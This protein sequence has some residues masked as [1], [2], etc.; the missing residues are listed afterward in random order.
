MESCSFQSQ[1]VSVMEI[2]AK[3]ALAEINRRVDASC[4]VLRLEISQSRRD[5]DSLRRKSELLEAELRRTRLRAR[6]RGFYPPAADRC[7]PLVRIVLNKERE[8]AAW[9]RQVDQPGQCEDVRPA[10]ES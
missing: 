10:A 7:S 3:A 8:A 1:L 6:R 2:V 5:I 9:D 4:A